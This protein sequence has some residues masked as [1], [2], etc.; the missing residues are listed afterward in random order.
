MKLTLKEHIRRFAG[1]TPLTQRR[2]DVNQT[3]RC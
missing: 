3:F 2:L 1:R